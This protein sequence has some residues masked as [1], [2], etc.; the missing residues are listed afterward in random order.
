VTTLLNNHLNEYKVHITFSE[1]DV[2]HFLL[3]QQGVVYT[4]V[5]DEKEDGNIT[6][7]CSFY[8]LPSQVIH[9]LPDNEEQRK[10]LEEDKGSVITNK[11][12][13]ELKQGYDTIN[14]AYCFY[15]V[16]KNNDEE[17]QKLVF[18]SMLSQA[19][20]KGFDVFNMVEV[21]Q[22]RRIAQDLL[23]KAGSGRLAHYLYNW[24]VPQLDA[25]DIGIVLV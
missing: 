14:A 12:G 16:T 19:S 25:P 17:R 23:F 22:N 20:Q 4:Y 18:K 6:D 21:L 1:Q 5:V 11:H 9:W 24:R 8:A 13:K 7:F 2:A 15:N 10:Q 3:P